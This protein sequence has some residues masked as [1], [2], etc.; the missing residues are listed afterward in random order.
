MSL[1][2]CVKGPVPTL[3]TYSV[4]TPDAALQ[5]KKVMAR[6]ER[7]AIREAFQIWLMSAGLQLPLRVQVDGRNFEITNLA[8]QI[9]EVR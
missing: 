1:G 2:D 4:R 6:D 5:A 7:F 8:L 3:C 9:R